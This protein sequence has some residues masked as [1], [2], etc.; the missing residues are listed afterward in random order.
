MPGSSGSWIS[1]KLGFGDLIS[2]NLLTTKY[3]VN[4]TN[5][6]YFDKAGIASSEKSYLRVIDDPLQGEKIVNYVTPSYFLYD[7]DSYGQYDGTGTISYTTTSTTAIGEINE[8]YVSSGGEGYK[9]TPLV[10]GALVSPSLEATADV[11]WNNDKKSIESVNLTS[12]GKNYV[13]PKVVVTDGDGYGAEFSATVNSDGSLN[14]IVVLS[15]GKNYSYKPSVKIVESNITGY[16]SGSTIGSPK[17]VKISYNGSNYENDSTLFREFTSSVFLTLKNFTTRDFIGGEEIK[18]Y[19]GTTLIAK[20]YVSKNNGWRKGSNILKIERVTYGKFIEN[21]SVYGNISYANGTVSKILTTVFLPDLRSYYD[22]LG[23]YSSDTS[24]IGEFSNRL[25]DSYYYQDY[26]YAIKSKTSI[27]DWRT[28]VNQTIH[29]AGFKVFGEMNI[30]SEGSNTLPQPPD[31][32]TISFVQLWNPQTNNISTKSVTYSASEFIVSNINTNS[33]VSTGSALV[34][35]YSTDETLSFELVINDDFDGYFDESGNRA[36]TKTFNLYLKSSNTPFAPYSANNLIVTLDGVLQEPGK[37]FT[38]NQSQITFAEAPLGYRNSSGNSVSSA[39]YKVGIDTPPQKFVC[40]YISFKLNTTNTSYFQKVKDISENPSGRF[41]DAA[42]LITNNKEFIIR[43]SIGYLKNLYPTSIIKDD[44]YREIVDSYVDSVI[45]DVRYSGNSDIITLSNSL[46]SNQTISLP[47]KTLDITKYARNLIIAATRNWD[48]VLENCQLTSGSSVVTVS[49]TYN[50]AVGMRVIGKGIPTATFVKEII[51]DTQLRLGNKA[52]TSNVNATFTTT[53]TNTTL[54]YFSLNSLANDPTSSRDVG[55]FLDAAKQIEDNKEFIQQEAYGWALATYPYLLTSPI[56]DITKCQR[57]I[58]YVLDAVIHDLRYG[59]NLKIIE[60]AEK[61]YVGNTLSFINNQKTESLATFN[62][63]LLLAK[64]AAQNWSPSPYVREFDLDGSF[65]DN[66]VSCV[67]NGT[68]KVA[69]TSTGNVYSSPVNNIVWTQRTYTGVTRQFNWISCLNN[70]FFILCK[71]AILKSTDGISWTTIVLSN[72]DNLQA[73]EYSS[74]LKYIAVGKDGNYYTSTDGNTWILN[75]IYFSDPHS[76]DYPIIDDYGVFFVNDLN[77]VV[78]Q[79]GNVIVASTN[80]RFFKTSDLTNW[81]IIET[82]QFYGDIVSITS[83]N[84]VLTAIT[85]IGYSLQ[86]SDGG[87]TWVKYNITPENQRDYYLSG[88]VYAANEYLAFGSYS[89]T[90]QTSIFGSLDGQT[91]YPL[92]QDDYA[93]PPNLTITFNKPSKYANNRLFVGNNGGYLYKAR[94][95]TYVKQYAIVDLSINPNIRIDSNATPYQLS[96]SD[97]RTAVD[98]L[99]GILQFIINN[100]LNKVTKSYPYPNPSGAF[101]DLTTYPDYTITQDYTYPE[102]ANVVSAISTLHTIFSSGYTQIT[103]PTYFDGKSTAFSLYYEDNTPVQL[104]SYENLIVGID[105]VLQRAGIT[106]LKPIDRSYYINRS[107]VP[108]QIVFVEPPKSFGQEGYQKFFAYNI[109]KY[110]IYTIKKNPSK[111]S[112][113]FNIISGLSGVPSTIGDY[114]Y[115]LVFVSGILQKSTSYQI[116]G[117]SIRFVE[118]IDPSAD[119]YIIYW[120]GKDFEKS[121]ILFGQEKPQAIFL[122]S[123]DSTTP[124]NAPYEVFLNDYI[125][126]HGERNLRKVLSDP[127]AYTKT[128]YRAEDENNISYSASVKVENGNELSFGN[129]LDVKANIQDGTVISLTWNNKD[130]SLSSPQPN[131][132]GYEDTP[133]LNFV[134]QPQVDA[135]GNFVANPEGGGAKGFAVCVDGQVIDVVLLDGGAGYVVPPLVYVAKKFDIIRTNARK[136]PTE[137]IFEFQLVTSS[138]ESLIVSESTIDL[139]LNLNCVTSLVTYPL[140]SPRP[141]ENDQTDVTVII[142]PSASITTLSSCQ[143]S[144]IINICDLSTDPITIV[145][146][147]YNSISVINTLST[148]NPIAS[149]SDVT[150]EFVSVKESG[151]VDYYTSF[152]NNDYQLGQLGSTFGTYEITKF[153]NFGFAQVSDMEQTIETFTLYHPTVTIGDFTTRKDSNIDSTGVFFNS[154]IPTINDF[155]ALLDIS[156]NTTDQTIYIPNTSRFANSG[157]ILLGDEIIYYANKLSDRFYNCTRGALGSVAKT[158]NAGDYLRTYTF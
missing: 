17:T 118:P 96:C 53:P 18:Q 99:Y 11:I 70:T 107:V 34:P 146:L 137:T 105:G 41:L 65:I 97:S 89:T 141:H 13:N 152:T 151:I 50:I 49:N 92:Q 75:E 15:G 46:T 85:N 7:L 57:D 28:L 102:C 136:F 52:R 116:V 83:I 117:S 121:L 55:Q 104:N 67:D 125:R 16:A 33:R 12:K 109:G 88:H 135:D 128:E 47:Q 84:N 108:N 115:A 24:K 35:F 1:I 25:A 103:A 3:P 26:S 73:I 61:Y 14:G 112:G 139:S 100:G 32:S 36:G 143:V 149:I 60:A 154:A 90:N 21:V 127:Y 114:R 155:G 138:V 45:H 95:P 133:I 76:T 130:Y 134:A 22:N 142:A 19:V 153:I 101:N 59:G 157:Y 124:L 106:P 80:G 122:P 140:I 66:L 39:N 64:L 98:N 156:V 4:Y 23:Y 63:A 93:F 10:I 8:I 51:N 145:D 158:H 27:E 38:I 20:G 150:R 131:N 82:S 29:P 58:G 77:D 123:I 129:G 147:I 87:D 111:I 91:W 68:T 94:V 62:Q 30:N 110:D 37:S 44:Y 56:V 69:I 120:Y 5:Y 148:E 79:N 72:N 126:I 71:G 31:T 42:N 48:V 132:Y 2:S 9:K 81:S 43:E 74:T 119:V 54:L 113:P 144:E 86:S 40:R 78:I 6:Y